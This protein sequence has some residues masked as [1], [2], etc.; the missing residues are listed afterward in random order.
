M[1]RISTPAL[2]LVKSMPALGHGALWLVILGLVGFQ[3]L[4]LVLALY[5]LLAKAPCC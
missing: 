2:F 3:A 4:F 5:N 1:S